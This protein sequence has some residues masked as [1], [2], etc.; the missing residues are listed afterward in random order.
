[1]RTAKVLSVLAISLFL[2]GCVP[3]LHSLYNDK[4]L[5]LEPA[6]NGTWVEKEGKDSWSFQKLGDK[7]YEVIYTEKGA[8]AKFEVH[9]ARLGK[10]LFADIYPQE[11]DLKNGFYK[12]HL[13]AVH[14]FAKI[15]VGADVL[16]I[17]MLDPDWLQKMTE[18]KKIQLAHEEVDDGLVLTAS[19]EDLQ[20][21]VLQYAED[22]KAFS[23]RSEWLR[24][25]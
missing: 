23:S 19:T 13:V 3:S 1:M 24:K 7:S 12:G 14:S 15:A 9:L 25:K 20:K 16:N 2:A 17:T 22:E 4:T 10:F 18:D 8:S 5:A 11:P 21:F 6:L